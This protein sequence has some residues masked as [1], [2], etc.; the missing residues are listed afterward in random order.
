MN[1]RAVQ[2]GPETRTYDSPLRRENAERTRKRILDATA[3]TIT[4]NGD[5]VVA[6][7]AERAGVAV[8]TIYHHFPDRESML[9]GLGEWLA[10]DLGYPRLEWP[11]DLASFADKTVGIAEQVDADIDKMRVFFSTPVGQ[12]ARKQ[13]RAR[14]LEHL[15]HLADA[16]LA[17]VDSQTAEWA[18]VIIHELASSRTWLA[19]HED[20]GF[21][22][23]E[24][25]EAV[26]WA[27][28]TLLES[29]RV[30]PNGAAKEGREP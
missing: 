19:M 16:E 5:F 26:R 27:I 25:A 11:E 4:E 24:A 21:G 8:R 30:E 1:S 29:L 2:K 10:E 15:R 12:A 3:A 20:A 14:R 6:E 7:V 17:H 13:G 9:D 22:V 18:V 23:I 28:Q